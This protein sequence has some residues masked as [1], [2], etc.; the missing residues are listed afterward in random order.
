[1]ERRHWVR[2]TSTAKGYMKLKG[3][4]AV[5]KAIMISSWNQ[6]LVALILEVAVSVSS[7]NNVDGNEKVKI[8]GPSLCPAGSSQIGKSSWVDERLGRGR[9]TLLHI[10]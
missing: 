5:P 6:R 9:G 2:G 7:E 1:L 10:G 8:I 3:L 4:K